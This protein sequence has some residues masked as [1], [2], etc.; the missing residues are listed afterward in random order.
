MSEL[1]KNWV[2]C[3]IGEVAQV[4]G[5]ATPASK[6]LTNFTNQDGVPWI[7]PADLSGYKEMYIDHGERNL[8]AKG[9][10]SCSAS[11]MPAGS[12]LFSS[13]API[14]YVAIASREV[15]TN[16]GFKSFVLPNGLDSRFVYYH[17]R[18]IKPVAEMMATGTTFKELSG[19]AAAK[20]PLVIPP[21]NEQKRIADKLDTLLARV[22]ACRVRL[23]RVPQVL[24]RFRQAVLSAATSGQLTE[25][26]REKNSGCVG[27]N[28]VRPG[29]TSKN[30]AD[31]NKGACHAP[32]Q[33]RGDWR[34]IDVQSVAMVGT[35]STPL[36]SNP[37]FYTNEGFPWI[38]S[39]ATGQS[40]VNTAS[41]FVSDAAISAHRLK[42][43]PVGTILIAM[44]GEGKTRGQVSELAIEATINQA[45]AAVVVDESLVMRAYVKLALQANYLEMR[46]L[47]EGGNQPNLNLS[48]I[49]D[50]PLSLPPSP[51][52][53]K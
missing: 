52:N 46:E 53:T 33:D 9:F 31:C 24:K 6:D 22:A 10:S 47:A 18:H 49:K 21:I 17:L 38:T 36:R 14:G 7:T 43:F 42:K 29:A 48:K 44:Y 30:G 4:V 2:S 23:D 35:G 34:E 15:S 26:W 19:A 50:F 27:A 25:D 45:C 40:F 8:S 3:E 51:N 39:A 5:G 37:N 11:K 12:V 13:R 41:E 20:L 16:Q 28:G 32:L 1:P